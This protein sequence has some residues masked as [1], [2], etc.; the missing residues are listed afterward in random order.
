MAPLKPLQVVARKDSKIGTVIRDRQMPPWLQV[1]L[2]VCVV[3]YPVWFTIHYRAV[4][5]PDIWWHMR[6]GEWVLQNRAV[7]RFDWLST[8]GGGRPW[9]LYSWI[10]DAVTAGLYRSFGL[11]GPIVVYPVVLV[12]LIAAVFATLTRELELSFRSRFLATAGT[13]VAIA[14]VCSPRPGLC[15]VLLFTVELW[16][17]LYARRT[18][19]TRILWTLPLLFAIWANI[20]VQFVY[21]LLVL[22]L[23]V[24]EP[25]IEPWLERVL[26]IPPGEKRSVNPGWL[27]LGICVASTLVNPYFIRLYEVILGL[28][29]QGGQY[30]Y[31]SELQPPSFRSFNS[32]T[33]LIVIV[34][35][36]F[37]IA[38]RR[39]FRWIPMCLLF[40]G[41]LFAF[42]TVRDVWFGVLAAVVAMGFPR[43]QSGT[44]LVR[45]RYS[46]IIAVI[47]LT[48]GGT[49]LIARAHPLSEAGL[50]KDTADEFPVAAVEYVKRQG[51]KGPL[52]NDWNWG[53]FLIWSLPEVPVYVD[54]RTN[55]PGD[56]ILER[57]IAVWSGAPDWASDPA[58]AGAR[59]II[60]NPN[61]ALTSLFRFDPRFRVAYEDRVAMVFVARQGGS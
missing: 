6:A 9:V 1:L 45:T 32:F 4:Y 14:P 25:W 13:L 48:I 60:A 31:I 20:H 22:A 3:L 42:R 34:A 55:L 49:L 50:W 37:V 19:S 52:Y 11:L 8:A 15:S 27:L 28:I 10:F 24:F 40:V 59:L 44:H 38:Y 51:L 21:G 58:L 61:N 53:G 39:D 16:I 5:D 35:A 36:W 57:S 23:F 46:I 41:T 43:A 56:E 12:L 18:G 29:T 33:E 7:P 54:S 17:L 26:G 47:L 30:G 2:L